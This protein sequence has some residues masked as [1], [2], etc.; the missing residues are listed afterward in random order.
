MKKVLLSFILA[1]S[2]TSL[3]AQRM[4]GIATSNW[5]GTN[6]ITLNPASIADSRTRFS[7]DLFSINFGIDNNLASVD[8]AKAAGSTSGTP[9]VGDIFTFSKNKAFNVLMPVADF[10]LPGIMV[11]IDQKNSVAITTRVRVFNQFNHFDQG[12]LRS[13]LDPNYTGG[14]D[15]A[16]SSQ[17]F[18]WTAN[19]WSEIRL[20][21]A[22]EVYNKDEHYIKAGITVSRLGGIGFLS[23]KGENLDGHYYSA[24]DSI[25]TNNTDLQFATSVVDNASDLSSGLGSIFGNF[26]D[27][28]SG[29]GWGADLGAIYEYRPEETNNDDQSN[30]KYKVRASL[31][32]TDLGSMSYTSQIVKVSANGSMSTGDL[33][34]NFAN[35]TDFTEYARSRGYTLDTSKGTTKVHLPTAMVLGLDYYVGSHFYINGTWIANLANRMNFG[36][37]Y[38]GQLTFTPRWDTRYFSVGVPLTYSGMTHGMKAGLGI[39]LAGLYFGSD[40][41]LAFMGGSYGVNFY[42]GGYI[43]INKKHKKMGSSAPAEAPEGAK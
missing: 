23:L 14:S 18:N 22:R 16:I 26:F 15:V 5:C 6:S 37:S 10:H 42:L 38:Y 19:I 2:I 34:K 30:N 28:K 8:F 29:S 17:K 40:D 32:I 9:Q 1:A 31:A 27:K 3:N 36:N 13:V 39:R 7:L 12:L 11:S 25:H 43:P 35:Y 24:S 4:M 41:M 33:A 21:Y 20:T